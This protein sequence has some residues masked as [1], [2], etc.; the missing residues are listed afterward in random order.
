[1]RV[2]QRMNVRRLAPVLAAMD[3]DKARAVTR[4]LADREKRQNGTPP[5]LAEVK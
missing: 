5:A 1:M 3:G 2:V 4:T